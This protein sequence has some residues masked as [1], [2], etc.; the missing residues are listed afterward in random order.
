MPEVVVFPWA[1]ATPTKRMPVAARA[2]ASERWTTL[3]PRPR[4]AASSGF[5]SRIAVDTT[6]TASAGTCAGSCPAKTVIPRPLSRSRT[7]ES[8]RSDPDT[9]A[10]REAR[11]SATTLMPA[12]PIPMKW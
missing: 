11:S 6:T 10:P 9:R 12:P 2:S 3:W 5:D 4:A 1:P 8:A 7:G